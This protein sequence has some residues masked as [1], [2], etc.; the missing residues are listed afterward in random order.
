[1]IVEQVDPNSGAILFKK[2]RESLLL[3]ELK[4]TVDS[5]VSTIEN[6]EYRISLLE[7]SK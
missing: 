1:M 6:L 3:E 4:N 7:N 5:L 2:D